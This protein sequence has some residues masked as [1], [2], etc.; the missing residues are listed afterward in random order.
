M[1]GIPQRLTQAEGLEVHE[2]QDGL[3]A[4]NPATDRVHHMNAT[5]SVLFE[6][7]DGTRETGELLALVAD[8]FSL[9]E[10]PAAAVEEGL[11]QLLN[12]GVLIQAPGPEVD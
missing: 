5:S 6:L 12:E 1:E 4:F 10:P 3:V 9:D 11:R 2:A 8:L 7:C